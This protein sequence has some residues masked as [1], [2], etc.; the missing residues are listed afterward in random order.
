MAVTR[1][2]TA[3]SATAQH[4]PPTGRSVTVADSGDP[5][6]DHGRSCFLRRIRGHSTVRAGTA[7]CC[8]EGSKERR[9]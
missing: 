5:W 3:Y 4:S 9:C 2:C 6:D 1:Q 7:R 8:K